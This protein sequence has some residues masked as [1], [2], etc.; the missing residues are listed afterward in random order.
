MFEDTRSALMTQLAAAT[1]PVDACS[2]VV[3][4]LGS[5]GLMP[6]AY[7]ASGD[8]LRLMAAHGYWQ[9]YDGMPEDAG[10][11]GTTWRTGERQLLQQ[12]H[13]HEDYLAASFL[14][15][16]ELCVPLWAR[17]TCVGALNVESLTRLTAEQEAEVDD[18][19]ALL[20]ARLGELPPGEESPAQKLNR[21]AVEL[22]T[23]AG[24]HDQQALDSAVVAAAIDLSG[25][26]T[27]VLVTEIE[28]ELQAVA[29]SG[30]LARSLALLGPGDFAAVASWVAR[31][32]SVYTTGSTDGVGFP[33]HEALRRAG[34]GS[35]VVLPL[36]T[37]HGFLLITDETVRT[38]ST[39][40]VA[41]LELLASQVSSCLQVSRAV[42]ELRARADRDA[43][44]SLGHHAAFQTALPRQRAGTR[45]ELAVLYCDVDHFKEVN[46]TQGHAAGDALLVSIA[47]ALR[48][49]VRE[50]DRVFRI[51]GDEF[52]VLAHVQDHDDAVTLGRR[53]LDAARSTTGASLSV[54]VA[55]AGPLEADAALLA[56]ADSALYEVK[57]GGRGNV[58][59][60]TPV[61]ESA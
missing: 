35:V 21:H 57:Q 23:L 39:E 25:H 15:T 55:V 20:S 41:L 4:H 5:L 34:A 27:A 58:L 45:R 51:G 48:S 3:N 18:C 52:A 32:T 36:R 56:R 13:G 19:A 9:V 59:L 14:V 10:V 24:E 1:R 7:L 28:G 42:A 29:S 54:G 30:P 40:Q 37:T 38:Q 26:D 8:R 47:A 44:T 49:A 12:V 11:I 50:D 6:S 53:L 46:D 43:L 60:Q 61:V 31:G 17:E 2:L 16:S 22:V 33:G